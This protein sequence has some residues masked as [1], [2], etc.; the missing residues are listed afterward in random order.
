MIKPHSTT[1]RT[2]GVHVY[3]YNRTN[4]HRMVRMLTSDATPPATRRA[5][6]DALKR[7]AACTDIEARDAFKVDNV[8]ILLRVGM[9][10]HPGPTW[11][12]ANAAHRALWEAF[13]EYDRLI[14]P[15]RWRLFDEVMR[16]YRER[17]ARER[18]PRARRA[19]RPRSVTPHR[20]PAP[21]TLC[22]SA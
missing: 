14:N 16:A 1:L 15:R 7:L 18:R 3:K 6:R 11:K 4:A 17:A 19:E 20:T 10:Y 13:N 8:A 22:A 21:L 12:R 2:A 5:M 9:T